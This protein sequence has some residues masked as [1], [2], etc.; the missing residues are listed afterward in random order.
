MGHGEQD[1]LAGKSEIT[2]DKKK[3]GAVKLWAISHPLG[4]LK[5]LIF[6]VLPD[7]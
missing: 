6:K 4:W 5:C 2:L 1:E 3:D 7:L